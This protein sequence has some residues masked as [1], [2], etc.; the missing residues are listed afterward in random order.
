MTVN[1]DKV[2]IEI[3]TREPKPH[4]C[5]ICGEPCKVPNH[6]YIGGY[7]GWAHPE[8]AEL[9][10]RAVKLYLRWIISTHVGVTQLSRDILEAEES[11]D[12]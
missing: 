5:D 1:K 4:D 11:F 7:L 10:E 12:T 9:A 8:C 3:K 2:F 6:M